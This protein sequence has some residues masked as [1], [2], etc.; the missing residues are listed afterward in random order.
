MEHDQ[1]Q[2]SPSDTVSDPGGGCHLAD[3]VFTYARKILDDNIP[4]RFRFVDLKTLM[5]SDKSR[6]PPKRQEEILAKLRANPTESYAFFGPAGT[7]K[8]TYSVALYRDAMR[9]FCKLLGG[10]EHY[11]QLDYRCRYDIPVWH[12]S[13]KTLLDDFVRESCGETENA[14]PDGKRIHPVVNRAKIRQAVDRGFRPCL[15]LEEI[16]KVKYTEFKANALFDLVDGIYESAGQLV[17]D[18]NLTPAGLAAK[19]GTDVD[20]EVVSALFR[21]IAAGNIYDFFEEETK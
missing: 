6:L 17:F 14:K 13:A 12:V 11:L 3:S 19:F 8:T 1:Q 7:G 2:T 20:A 16:D 21:R 15:F 9:G 18:T 4:S 5:P 10:R